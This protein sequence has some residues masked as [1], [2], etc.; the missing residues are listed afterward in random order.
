MDIKKSLKKINKFLTE[1][2][3]ILELNQLSRLKRLILKQVRVFYIVAKSFFDDKCQLRS[4]AL[5]FR[6]LLSI[7]P[8]FALIF[9]VAKGLGFQKNLEPILLEKIAPGQEQVISNILQYIENTN[10]KALGSIGLVFLVWIVISMLSMIEETFNDVW[11]IR[12]GRGI[13]RKFSDYLSIVIVIPLVFIVVTA[14]NTILATNISNMPIMKIEIVKFF[15]SNLRLILPYL[16][17]CFAFIGIYKFMPNT[18]VNFSAAFFGGIIGGTIWQFL[19]WSYINFQMGVS[20]YN[21]IYGAFATFPIFLIWIYISWLVL[22]LGAEISFAYQNEENYAEERTSENTAFRLKELLALNLMYTIAFNF[23][24]GKTEQ[25]AE[26]LAHVLNVP[27]R[28]IRELLFVMNKKGLLIEIPKDEK[29]FLYHPARPIQ[30]I[31][32]ADVLGALKSHGTEYIKIDESLSRYVLSEILKKKE[33]SFLKSDLN[34]NFKELLEK[35]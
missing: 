32:I 4:A 22:L 3:W 7:V 26:E 9:A 31:T 1:D 10:V 29:T 15:V 8:F 2:I 6:T 14:L 34:K 35:T 24:R 17:T 33:T 28:L 23:E 20:R 12:R 5:T 18:K 13:L 21:A 16:L 27:V 30:N 25:T 19:E 11:G